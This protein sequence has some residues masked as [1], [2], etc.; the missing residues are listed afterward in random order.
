MLKQLAGSLEDTF[1]A[2]GSIL[3]VARELATSAS[4]A[5]LVDVLRE[6]VLSASADRVSLIQTGFGLFGEPVTEAIAT[7]D[8][9]GHA[10]DVGLPDNLRR[11]IGKQPLVVSNVAALD[12]SFADLADYAREVIRAESLAIFPLVGRDRT[13]GYLLIASRTPHAYTPPE[14]QILQALAT[15]IA[16]VLENLSLLEA[17]GRKTESLNLINDTSRLLAGVREREDLNRAISASLAGQPFVAHLS[18]AWHQ[19]EQPYVTLEVLKGDPL[20]PYS[21]LAGTA[22]EQALKGREV[23]FLPDLAARDDAALFAGTGA[24]MLVL[25][26][27]A[28]RERVYGTLNIGIVEGHTFGIG[29]AEVF[30][31]LAAQIAVTVQTIDLFERLQGSLNEATHL[32]NTA[33]ALNTAHS[34]DDVINT[35]LAEIAQVSGAARMMLYL[36]GPDPRG[37]VAY[38]TEVVAGWNNGTLRRVSTNRRRPAEVPLLTQFPQPRANLIFNNLT[39]PRLTEEVRAALASEEATGLMVIPLTAGAAWLGVL[40]VEAQAE[41]QFT[42]DQARLCRTIADQAALVLDSQLLLQRAE[43]AARREQALRQITERIRTADTPEGVV[44]MAHVELRQALGRT[45]EELE[46]L[47][48]RDEQALSAE[49]WDLVEQVGHQVDLAIANLQLMAATRQTA[50]HEQ[51][52]GLMVSELQRAVTVEDVLETAA[53]TLRDVLGDYEVSVRLRTDLPDGARLVLTDSYE[54]GGRSQ[55]ERA[56]HSAEG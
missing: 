37:R 45:P 17:V 52:V 16:V 33:L 26:P 35:A 39:D 55:D 31:Q 13:A 36:A 11:R 50:Q 3:D 40:A 22:I 29:D 25:A 56:G 1:V 5:Q 48:W 51:T 30:R 24:S 38:Y 28:I 7:W 6:R 53:R 46:R 14:V 43:Q 47:Q 27:L 9:G 54:D 12:R 8:A 21:D 34:A 20:P 41:Q 42:S 10:P 19:A 2:A 4:P 18:L 32:Y 49:E 15:Q 23:L 44:E